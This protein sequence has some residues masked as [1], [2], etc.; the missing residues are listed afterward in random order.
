M[1]DERAARFVEAARRYAELGWAL[2]PTRG[3][4]GGSG[5]NMARPDPPE[6][7]AGKWAH[8]GAECNLGVVLGPSGLV[9]ADA[10]TE[11][12]VTRLMELLEGCSRTPAV[13]TGSGKLH[14]YFRAGEGLTPASRDGLEL[15]AGTQLLVLPPSEHPDTGEPY[16][17]LVEPEDAELADVPTTVLAYFAEKA[18]SN[19][20][21][22]TPIG[23]VIPIGQ[24]DTTLT[25]LAGTMRR[26]GMGEDAIYAALVATLDRCEPGHTHTEADCRRIAHSI[27]KK[28]P[29]Q[30][31]EQASEPP[32]LVPLDLGTL[33]TGPPPQTDWLWAGWIARGDVVLLAADPKVGKSLLTLGFAT[34]ARLGADFLRARCAQCRVGVLDL[35]NPLDEAHKRL[36]AFGVT[37]DDHAGLLYYHGQPLNL[38]QGCGQLARMIEEHAV[39]VVIIDSLRR[40]VPGLD[41]NDSRSVSAVLS[42]LKLLAQRTGVTIVIVHH[43]RKRIGDNPT[44]AGQMVRGSGDLVAGVDQ[45]LYLRAKEPGTFTLEHGASRRSLPHEPILVRVVGDDNR[46]ELV[47]EGAVAMAEDKLE[48]VLAG[49]IEALRAGPLERKVLALRV[50]VDPKDG[51]FSR[52]LNLGWQRGQLT[53]TNEQTRKSNEPLV[54]A[55]S[56]EMYQ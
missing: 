23:D 5:W 7:A 45:L 32:A 24:I 49:I 14:V 13:R 6:L 44:E 47:N 56:P 53:K 34:A 35:E 1:G 11:E 18:S 17:W 41:E 19:G 8:W 10:D 9:V 15:R 3:K 26:R 46:I 37:A 30:E 38:E 21:A 43:A 25:S 48:A 28:P 52:A 55:L 42:P 31:P 16:R 54:Y 27:A 20:A 40:A 2:V 50:D 12:A 29:Q 22:A 33:L 51:T 4:E 36:L 39:D